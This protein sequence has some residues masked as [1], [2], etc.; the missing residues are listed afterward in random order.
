MA[1][2]P[3]PAGVLNQSENDTANTH[4][5]DSARPG[6]PLLVNIRVHRCVLGTTDVMLVAYIH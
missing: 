6:F 3:A 1:D 5:V 2:R 4:E